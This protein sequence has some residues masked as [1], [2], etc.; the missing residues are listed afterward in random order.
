MRHA[1]GVVLKWVG[2]ALIL[3]APYVI[4]CALF[5]PSGIQFLNPVAC[6][7]GLELNNA[8]F[9]GADRPD[10]AK[11]EV[12]CTSSVSSTSAGREVVLI[13]VTLLAAGIGAL[14]ISSRLRTPKYLVPGTTST[15]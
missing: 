6:P 9:A 13:V 8:R 2:R 10:N 7:D 12:V 5:L 15:S 11:L 14:Y 1:V 3:A 4:V